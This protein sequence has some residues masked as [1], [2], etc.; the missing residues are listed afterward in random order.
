M[1]PIHTLK[2]C[3]LDEGFCYSYVEQVYGASFIPNSMLWNIEFFM[4]VL[5]VQKSILLSQLIVVQCVFQAKTWRLY[6]IRLYVV[7][8]IVG[9]LSNS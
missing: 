7:R 5:L 4:V 1:I 9:V 3:F 2:F 8:S 6:F